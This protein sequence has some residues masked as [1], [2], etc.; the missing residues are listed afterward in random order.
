MN[1]SQ[2][3]EQI[4]AEAEAAAKTEWQ[5]KDFAPVFYR[6]MAEWH[7]GGEVGPDP[8][9]NWETATSTGAWSKNASDLLPKYFSQLRYRWTPSTK[10]TEQNMTKFF[11]AG[12]AGSTAY[13]RP[14]EYL[15]GTALYR[16]MAD[17]LDGGREVQMSCNYAP[18]WKKA[19]GVYMPYIY[20]FKPVK[21]RTVTIGYR[22]AVN[23]PAPGH[24]IENTFVAPEVEAPPSQ[25]FIY[26]QH[27]TAGKVL[28][29]NWVGADWQY[30]L[31]NG[32]K[33]F[34]AQEDAQA[35]AEWLTK[36]RTGQT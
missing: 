6:A 2:A 32:G 23:Y 18:E 3:I 15:T 20:R 12:I 7:E 22:D 10:P 34:L 8:K 9:A 36:C 17:M 31:L 33:I 35:M 4:R 27:S 28:R 21:K 24:M 25:A 11:D 13:I 29:E 30:A 19:D 14:M 26:Y 16:A 5:G 1:A